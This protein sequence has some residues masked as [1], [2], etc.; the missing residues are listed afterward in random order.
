MNY[1]QR[2]AKHAITRGAS[3]LRV[4]GLLLL[5]CI[6][7]GC[8]IGPATSPIFE[9]LTGLDELRQALLVKEASASQTRDGVTVTVQQVYADAN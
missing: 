6:G 1:R 8:T 5:A 3:V 9:G 7:I 4:I 2:A